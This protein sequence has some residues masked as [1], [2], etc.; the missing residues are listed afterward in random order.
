MEWVTGITFRHC[1]TSMAN[2][3]WQISWGF[4]ERLFLWCLSVPEVLGGKQLSASVT[5][6]SPW[7]EYEF[8][9]L[10]SNGIGTGE[11]SKPSKKVRTK[12]TRTYWMLLIFCSMPF[13]NIYKLWAERSNCR[14]VDQTEKDDLFLRSYISALKSDHRFTL[15]AFAFA[16]PSLSQHSTAA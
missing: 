9:V 14:T 7:V 5:D 1:L 11:P 13:C 12:E 8:R 15:L 3:Q 10:A 2:F 6:L 16:S 4:H